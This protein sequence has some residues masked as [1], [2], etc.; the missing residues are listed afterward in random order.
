MPDKAKAAFERAAAL[1]RA[2]K[3]AAAEPI[4]R[5]LLKASP[6]DH[7]VLHLLGLARDAVGAGD[8]AAGLIQAAI[9]HDRKNP[10]YRLNLGLV[11]AKREKF[12]EALEAFDA[13]LELAPKNIDALFNGAVVLQRMARDGDA[14][15]RLR[16][17][18]A[19]KPGHVAAMNN[20][21]NLLARAGAHGEAAQILSRAVSIDGNRF[22]ARF[23]LARVLNA[24]GE[25]DAALPH[26]RIC[27]EAHPSHAESRAE[28]AAALTHT[29]DYEAGIAAYDEALRLQPDYV[30]AMTNKGLALVEMGKASDG[31]DAFLKA[32]QKAPDHAGVHFNLSLT[33]RGTDDAGLSAVYRTLESDR[34]TS[35]NELLLRFAAGN[36]LHAAGRFDEA[37][38]EYVRANALEK[39]GYDPVAMEAELAD[40]IRVFDSEFFAAHAG[41]GSDSDLPIFVVGMPRSGTS[42]VEQVLASHADVFG[43]GERRTFNLI[44]TALPG[45]VGSEKNYPDCLSVIEADHVRRLSGQLLDG[46]RKLAPGHGRI[47]DKL[48]GNFMHLGLIRLLFPRATIIHCRRDPMDT[49]LSC[50]VTR[51]RGNL[52]FAYALDDLAHYY[53]LYRRLM[54]HWDDVL[55]GAIIDVDYESLVVA[56]DSEIPRLIE[57][58]GLVWDERCLRPHETDRPVRT[59]SLLQVRAPINT[60]SVER[61]RRYKKHLGPLLRGL[62]V[63]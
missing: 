56:P 53:T 18:L 17:L 46:I 13:A 27:T 4:Y 30:D 32:L 51:F 20:L 14:I 29:G 34:L 19:L 35:E 49:C 41:Q 1:H 21:G 24:M 54:S 8:E 33:V 28:L 5:R 44:P 7:R 23:N 25:H 26:A 57:A 11:L 22:E 48:P 63:C 38:A 61:W 15:S 6:G 47:V 50:F 43:A 52:P 40:V 36:R 16:R 12:A 59:A 37:F 45:F 62:G 2:G 60:A 42:L 3:P 55:P 58:C 31:I 10:A 9:D 39:A